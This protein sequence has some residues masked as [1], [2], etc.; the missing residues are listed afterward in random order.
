MEATSRAQQAAERAGTIPPL[1]QVRSDVW[2]LA[3]EMPG[4]HIPYSLCYLLR[5]S[6]GGVHLVDPGWDTEANWAALLAALGEL[7]GAPAQVP[8]VVATHLHPDHLGMAHRVRRETGARVILH[9]REQQALAGGW[10]V[11]ATGPQ[12]ESWGVPGE[13]RA[14]MAEVH[15]LAAASPEFHADAVVADGQRLDIPGF[16]LLAVWTPGHTAGHLSLRDDA[17]ALI[18]TGD[19][20]LPSIF[21]G[22]GL[23]GPSVTNPLADYLASL[24]KV[25]RFADYEVLPGHGY[26]FTGLV[27]RAAACAEHHGIRS[28]QVRDVL[29]EGGSPTVW[30]IASRLSWTAGWGNLRGYLLY[31]ALAQTAM[32]REYLR[33]SNHSP[34]T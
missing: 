12:L 17:R 16:D 6:A 2:A 24:E 23:G 3:L 21:S 31:S 26:R 11:A 4:G 19:H 20:V 28:R 5:D 33:D 7:G 10:A 8:S 1:E 9:E 18:F 15:A 14:E 32:H 22:L 13:R 27:E 30:E 34:S 25:A 29:A